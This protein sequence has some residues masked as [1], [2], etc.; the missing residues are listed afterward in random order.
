MTY[1][2]AGLTNELYRGTKIPFVRQ[3]NNLFIKHNIPRA[4]LAAVGTLAEGM[5]VGLTLTLC[6]LIRSY[7][8]ID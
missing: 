1:L 6:S 2:K 3:V 5:N 7:P 4:L 8:W